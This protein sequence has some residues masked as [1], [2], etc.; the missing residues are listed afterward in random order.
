MSEQ[1]KETQQYTE[2]WGDTVVLKE[3]LL[4]CVIGVVLTMSFF[5]VGRSIFKGMEGLDSGMANGYSLL[6]GLAGCLVS[7]V[8]NAKLFKPKRTFDGELRSDSIEHILEQAGLTVEEEAQALAEVDA[9]IIAELED[10]E[11]YSLLALIP[12]GSKNYK[13]EYREKAHILSKEGE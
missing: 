2:V 9:E 10:L 6:V 11:M 1:K 8:I 12:E 3:L 7:G 5:F 4:A 13:P